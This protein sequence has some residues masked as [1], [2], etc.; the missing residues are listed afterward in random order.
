[1]KR[2]YVVHCKPREDA[3]AQAHLRNQG[4][5]VFRPVTRVRRRRGGGMAWCTESLF[6]RY[7]FVRLDDVDECWAPI[8]STRG[9]AGLVR[10]GDHV[11]A[12]PDPVI[13]GLRAR[14]DEHDAID[15][16]A[17]GGDWRANERV[18]VESGPF[19]GF[20]AVFQARS[21]EERVIVLLE[22][23]R[24][25]QRVTVAEQAVRRV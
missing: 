10:W 11:P 24:R 25:V 3:R 20:E 1:M 7:L 12:V 15:P 4:Y 17:A 16:A 13:D 19:A 9:V 6:P 14:C 2:W 22:F 23:M 18:R 21:G 8:R 5:A